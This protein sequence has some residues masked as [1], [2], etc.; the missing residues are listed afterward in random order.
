MGNKGTPY[1]KFKCPQC[2]KYY[3]AYPSS[4]RK[5]C[6]QKCTGA[7]KRKNPKPAY[8]EKDLN[9][10]TFIYFVQQD[11]GGPIK[12][13]VSQEP[14]ARLSQLQV[15]NPD[16]LNLLATVLSDTKT[17]QQ[18]HQVFSKDSIRGEWFRPSNGLITFIKVLSKGPTVARQA[19]TSY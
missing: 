6:S 2:G 15:G 19:T 13:G 1:N 14:A 18:L 8:K 7:A 9:E 11:K 16:S 5:Y 17:E 12:I 10:P 3:A 4:N